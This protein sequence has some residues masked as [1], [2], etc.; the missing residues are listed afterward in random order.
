[1]PTGRSSRQP[2]CKR[3]VRASFVRRYWT[4]LRETRLPSCQMYTTASTDRT[5]LGDNTANK[6]LLVT[7]RWSGC[8]RPRARTA[9]ARVVNHLH[10]SSVYNK[11]AIPGGLVWPTQ[12]RRQTRYHQQVT[13]DVTVTE[14]NYSSNN[15]KS[16]TL[17]TQRSQFHATAASSKLVNIW[18][19]NRP[20]PLLENL[21]V[22]TL[23]S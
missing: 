7:S 15:K 12:G 11:P 10:P 21:F 6:C 5:S 1:M 18:I 13:S 4:V 19:E 3:L 17:Q 2:Y 23:I 22:M 9:C 20:N 8:R 14:G 16:S